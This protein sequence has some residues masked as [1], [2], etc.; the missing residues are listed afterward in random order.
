MYASESDNLANFKKLHI[1]LSDAVLIE[2]AL[3]QN[4]TNQLS[5]DGSL[6]IMTGKFTGRAA[7]D[8][9]VVEDSFTNKVIDWHNNIRQ[10]P[11]QTFNSL[12]KDVIEKLNNEESLFLTSRS[13]SANPKYA[14]QIQ[15]ITPSAAH[16]LFAN[17]IF[18]DEQTNYPL[19]TFTIYHAP[20]LQ[21]DHT[22]YSLRSSTVI[23]INFSSKEILIIGTGYAGE[24]KKSIFSVLNTL[25]PDEGV[26]PMHSGANIDKNQNTSLFFGLSGTGKTTLST[27]FNVDIIGDDEHGMSNE[28]IFNFEGGCYAKTDGL[29]LEKEPDIFRASNRFKS[30]L[31]NV[32]LDEKTRIPD[33]NN[34]TITEN[35][36]ATYS[37]KSLN[38]IAK[39]SRG[40]IPS[41]IFFLSADA[42]GVL[43]AISLLST[44]QA[45]YYF[46]MGYT[47]KL[48]GTEIGLKNIEVTF[49]HCFGAP[50]MMRKAEDYANLLR[51]FITQYPIKVW[52]VNTGWYGGVYGKG[53][54]YPLK[55]TRECIRSIQNDNN[56]DD[57]VINET[58][59]LKIPHK[60]KNVDQHF[61]IPENLWAEKAEYL[62]TANDLK[63]KFEENFK[64]VTKNY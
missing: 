34:K 59:N 9:Y 26:L 13:A 29:S 61:L 36:R 48:A 37:L 50:F 5:A 19:G 62:K 17:N 14:L 7:N 49:S 35:G 16:A 40:G 30:L 44:E 38:N 51:K 55:I 58:F 31:E 6:V 63:N 45:M 21:A 20:N 10:M 15:L 46:L 3:K 60:L 56:I 53:S 1:N 42:L 41:N 32:V 43:P 11:E 39:D 47:A 12:K 22:K 8:K 2:A 64:K 25:L 24:I 18:R 57:F 4:P 33:F 23:A 54:R 27:D 52:L 28:G